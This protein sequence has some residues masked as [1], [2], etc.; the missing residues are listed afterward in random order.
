MITLINKG[1]HSFILF[2]LICF[3]TSLKSQPV[4][5]NQHIS[6]PDHFREKEKFAFQT[7]PEKETRLKKV[8]DKFRHEDTT[9]YDM[10]GDLLRDDTAYNKKYPWYIAASRVAETDVFI[11]GIDRLVFNADFSYIGLSSSRHNLRTG[12]EWDNDRFGI[13]FVGHPYSGGLFYVD[14][15]ANGYGFF[16]SVPFAIGGSLLWE[17]FGENTKPSYNDIINTPIS[18]ILLGEILYRVSSNIIDDRATGF[19]RTMR[20]IAV[21]I[22]AP[23]REFNRLIQGKHKR[24]IDREIYE[25]G[26]L[27]ITLYGGIHKRNILPNKVYGAGPTN[28]ILNVQ[29]DYG[30]PFEERW[31][32]PFDYFKFRIDLSFGSGRK[33]LDNVIGYGYLTGQN[34]RMG[35]IDLL[36]GLFQNFDYWDNNSFELGSLGFGPGVITRFNFGKNNSLYTNLL[37]V[38]APM[39]GITNRDAIVSDTIQVRDYNYG[40]G[41]EGKFETTCNFGTTATASFAAYYYLIRTYFGVR[42]RE[43]LGILKP[44]I[45]FNIYKKVSIGFEHTIFYNNENFKL[46]PDVH[47][48]KTEQKIFLQIFFEDPRRNGKYN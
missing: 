7:E 3:A 29:L 48:A 37:I 27:N 17:Y 10:Y 13:N 20:E 9:K 36:T 47:I 5:F 40:G 14:A 43:F 4:Y 11:W 30:N 6:N 1:K 31:R 8:L 35:K 42:Q 33:I 15:R 21:G 41:L 38:Y 18:G 45:A 32:K 24:V 34:K 12:F 22:I 46:L 26:P 16:E 2:L 44:K 25:K 39:A 28:P 23:T 19:N